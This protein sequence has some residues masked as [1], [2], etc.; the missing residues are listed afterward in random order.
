MNDFGCKCVGMLSCGKWDRVKEQNRR[1]Y[2]ADYISPT[3]TTCGG[4][5]QEVKIAVP[6]C[7]G[8]VNPSGHGINGNVYSY[9]GISTT[10]TTNKG[11]GIKV[12]E[13]Q[14]MPF[15]V[16]KLTPKESWRL[17]GFDD[18]SFEKAEQVNSNSQ[19]YKQAGNSIVV[20]VLMAIFGEMLP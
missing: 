4:G 14:K 2:S 13:P 12:T 3:L 17:M 18:G 5:N 1:V 6:I 8:N 7:V 11:E 16:R 19:L 10:L 15:R 9:D 20:D